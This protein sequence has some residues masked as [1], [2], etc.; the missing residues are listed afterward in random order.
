MPTRIIE[1]A[2]FQGFSPEALKFLKSLKRNNKREWFQPRKEQYDELLKHP[3]MA[4]VKAIGDEC[5]KF[6]PELRFIPERAVLRIY[7]DTRFSEDKTPYKDYVAASIPFLANKKKMHHI[8]VYFELTPGQFMIFAG[9]YQ[10]EG[11][12]LR[13]IR[14][15]LTR[16][17]D[18]FFEVIEDPKFKKHFKKLLGEKLKTNPRGVSPD[19]PMIDFLRFKQFYVMKEFPE[20]AAL[21]KDLPKIVA[22]EFEIAMPLLRWLNRSLKAW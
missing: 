3:M 6:A 2:P 19:H 7:R 5:R 15:S 18:A 1:I 16:N 17:P 9:L 20:S 11:D 4:L 8:G 10:P 21:R 22:K 13:K 12:A 14:E